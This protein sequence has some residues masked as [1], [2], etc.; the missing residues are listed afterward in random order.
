MD[1]FEHKHKQCHPAAEMAIT[2]KIFII[3]PH[4]WIEKKSMP[5]VCEC[6]PVDSTIR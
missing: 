3:Q 6:Q 4:L 2:Q 1:T 5:K